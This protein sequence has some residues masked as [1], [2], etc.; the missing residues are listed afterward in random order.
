ESVKDLSRP[1]ER[2]TFSSIDYLAIDS[3]T[4][5]ELRKAYRRYLRAKEKDVIDGLV[6]IAKEMFMRAS[7]SQDKS[8]L[9]KAITDARNKVKDLLNALDR[10]WPAEGS[11]EL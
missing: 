4:K 7:N 9:D 11:L 6:R 5:K 1:G 10:D 3:E 8:E 2:V